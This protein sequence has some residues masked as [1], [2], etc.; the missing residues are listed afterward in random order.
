MKIISIIGTRPQLIKS[1]AISKFFNKKKINHQLLDTGQHYDKGL[2]KIFI[3]KIKKN[4]IKYTKIKNLKNNFNFKRVN[5]NISNF[6]D[7][8]KP[9][10]VIVY[11]DTN[12][13]L[14]GAKIAYKKNIEIMHIE[15][16]LRSGNNSMLEETNR[17][18]T[19]HLS[20]YLIAPTKT[21]ENNLIREKIDKNKIFNFGDILL[22]ISFEDIK[23][24]NK[25]IKKKNFGL[26]TLH[27][28]EI[29]Y[30][31]KILKSLISELE[32]INFDFI[33]PMHPHTKKI[34]KKNNLKLPRNIKIVKLLEHNLFKK[35]LLESKIILTDS[36]GVQREAYFYKKN[37]LVI[38]NETEWP[39]AINSFDKSIVNFQKIKKLNKI[40]IE[41]I[42]INANCNYRKFGSG[43]AISKIYKLIKK[44]EK[45]NINSFRRTF[46]KRAKSTSHI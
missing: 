21:A 16:G 13:T 12:S 41:N 15:A 2:S 25:K 4:K 11:G 45:K 1:F 28:R 23:K 35:L 34:I 46:D 40:I 17:V 8:Y 10:L 14:L 24:K 19:D 32:K 7:K 6:L 18:K 36:G 22:D 43:K 31:T 37:F 30:N 29:L 42:G 3:K 38:R 26:I 5:K 9:D 39:E 27:R 33:F 20:K 44:I